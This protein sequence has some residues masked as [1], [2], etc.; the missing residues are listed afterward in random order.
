MRTNE[1]GE[2]IA[3]SKCRVGHRT[4]KC[5]DNPDHQNDV[6]VIRS[7]G[8][9]SGSR[10][11]SVRAAKKRDKKRRRPMKVELGKQGAADLQPHAHT[12]CLQCAAAGPVQGRF[13]AGYQQLPVSGYQNPVNFVN[14]PA[15]VPSSA[16]RSS[17]LP[18]PLYVGPQEPVSCPLEQPA[19]PGMGFGPV[20]PLPAVPA[21]IS[22][23][24]APVS[25]PVVANPWAAMAQN[26]WVNDPLMGFPQ[27][28]M[29]AQVQQAGN[30]RIQTRPGDLMEAG[31]IAPYVPSVPSVTPPNPFSFNEEA[32][33]VV[34]WDGW[35]S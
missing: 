32:L 24:S 14:P 34:P 35:I 1:R 23:S 4:G 22:V 16:Q 8:R 9:P 5:V 18:N 29:T 17:P 11:D 13:A 33:G 25:Q 28:D 10:T 19:Y 21:P 15:L 2:K 31:N 3:C 6:Q 20:S 12:F 7:Q 30:M 27:V 26:V